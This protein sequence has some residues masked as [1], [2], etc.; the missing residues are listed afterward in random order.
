MNRC[1]YCGAELKRGQKFCRGH[2]IA[3]KRRL[4]YLWRTSLDAYAYEELVKYNWL[5]DDTEDNQSTPR[6]PRRDP[7]TPVEY[8]F[9]KFGIELETCGDSMDAYEQAIEFIRAGG[10]EIRNTGYN[11]NTQEYW[12][13]LTDGSLSGAYARELVSPPFTSEDEARKS[14]RNICEGASV[15]NITVDR[16][17][18]FHIHF[19]ISDMTPQEVER[20]LRFYCAYES[21]IDKLHS[22]SRRAN[23]NTY[24]G[25][26]DINRLNGVT[27]QTMSD[28]TNIYT[29]RYYKVNLQA[30]LRHGTLEFRQHAGT[31][32]F[33][34]IWFWMMFCNR[35]LAWAKTNNRLNT[36]IP[37]F[38]ALNLSQ[39]ERI[40][41]KQREQQL[42]R[43][44][45]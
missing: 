7:F 26:M 43:E 35:V 20:A 18:G 15:T 3:Y 30:Y 22:Q 19:D 36:N 5:P 37:M 42:A 24:C 10:T 33:T 34:K 44:A 11:H 13:V 8:E 29:S 41:W 27:V 9:R 2:N 40:Y 25:S 6:A 38:D 1:P 4:L 28:L 14:I 31:V 17:C 45:A 23:I 16:S 12:K 39:R 32:N 21:E